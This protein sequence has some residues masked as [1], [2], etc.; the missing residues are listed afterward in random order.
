MGNLLLLK[1]GGGT[2]TLIVTVTALTVAMLVALTGA[3]AASANGV[4]FAK[5]DVL[6]DV[7]GGVIAHLSPSGTLLDELNTTTGTNEGDGM[8]FD[9]A[10]NLYATQGFVANTMSKF[11]ANGNLLAANFGSGFNEHPESCIFNAANEMYVGQPDGSAEVLKF[12]TSGTLL[13]SFAPE[14]EDRGT[15]W[16][17]L[18]ADQCTLNYT[19]EGGDINRYNVCTHTQLTPFATGLPAPCYAH[20]ILPDGS[21][22]VACTSVIEHVNAAGEIIQT[23][24]PGGSLLFALNLDPDGETFWTADYFTGTV[25]RINIASGA[26]VTT[27]SVAPLN[28]VLGGLA[29]VGELTQTPKIELAPLTAENPVGTTHTVTATVTEGGKPAAKKSV[30]F[31]VTGANPQSGEGTTNAAGEATFTYT[32]VNAGEDT[33]VASFEDQAGETVRSNPVTKTWVE[34]EEE[35]IR[36]WMTGGGSVFTGDGT[37]VTHGFELHCMPA[38]GPNDLQVN[39]GK[40]NRFH[41]TSLTTASCS[42]NPAISP[43]SPSAGFDTLEGAGTGTYNGQPGARAK[44]T[45][46]D[47]GEPGTDDTAALTV[48][49]AGHTVVLSVSGS[50]KHGNQ[51]AHPA[52]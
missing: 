1:R 2:M 43:G 41:L 37:R 20:R 7:G 49:D 16:L 14:V 13:E 17:D 47:A 51:Q 18:A 12:N 42:D 8:C 11:D 45:F 39:W 23:Y 33:I 38:D 21:E 4:P 35:E 40:G 15:D 27:F 44:W 52:S 26:V 5:G 22:L 50:L 9:A 3:S 30:I 31:T 28:S 32:G 36:G 46:T 24:A 10:G 19:S 29:I 48:E 34:E 6:A 25:F